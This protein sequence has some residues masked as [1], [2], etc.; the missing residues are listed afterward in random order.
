M[1]F[2][3]SFTCHDLL[4]LSNELSGERLTTGA[5]LPKSSSKDGLY[6]LQALIRPVALR[7]KY[8]FEGTRQT[9]RLDKVCYLSSIDAGMTLSNR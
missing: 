5:D 4:Y 3:G 9:N 6:P 8:H 7:F 2:H 1:R